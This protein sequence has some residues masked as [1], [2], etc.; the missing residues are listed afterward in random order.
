MK[1]GLGS[2]MKRNYEEVFKYR[3]PMRMPVIIR[4]D[5]KCFHT[6]TRGMMKP[7]DEKLIYNM[8]TVAHFLCEKISGA[9]LA[10]VQSDE[11]SILL[12]GYKK[13]DSEPWF[14]NEVQKMVSISASMAS[15]TMSRLYNKEVLFDSRVFVLP[16]AEVCNYFIWRQKDAVRNSI[17]MVAQSL[18][19]H[20][21]LHG[22]RSDDM[23]EMIFQKGLNW[24][25]ISPH[26][27]HG[28]TVIKGEHGWFI[29]WECPTFTVDRNYINKLLEVEDE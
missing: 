19:S 22:K 17:S 6:F 2:R 18:Y 20:K 11:I 13:L 5:G 26:Q 10:Y 29:D 14:A 24:N 1:N 12:H 3:L 27:K 28:E 9:Q 16:E 23:Q 7:F 4:L 21:Q 8:A 15:S 25:D